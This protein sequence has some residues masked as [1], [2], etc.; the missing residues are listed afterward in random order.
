MVAQTP[1]P[2]AFRAFEHAGW[3]S[4]VTAYRDAWGDL[5]SQAIEPL[6]D[7]VHAGPGVRILDV[8]T[9]PGYVAGAA[10]RRHAEVVGV[11]F[12]APM[13]AEARRREPAVDFREGDAETLPF[14]DA[15]FD[16]VVMSFGLLHLGRPEQALAEAYRVLRPGGRVGFTVWARPEEAVGFE[17]VLGAIHRHGRLDV[18]LPPGP[19]FFRFSDPDECRRVLTGLGFRAPEVVVVPQ[20][21]RH[22]SLD[23]LFDVMRDG[24]V[25]T[26]GLL[27]AQTPA[28]QQAI[29]DEVREAV[30]R[31]Q[32]ADTVELPMPAI[33]AAA[34]KP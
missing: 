17:I 2:A 13:L 4:V 32:R 30:R 10:A 9:G 21:W 1:D 8:A 19:P 16:A 33:L 29:R 12:S 18:P 7:A 28:A 23:G 25:R 14:P 31:Y 6:L 34:A 15:R 26:A 5:T 22:A 11:D 20:V 3:Q 27:R 24:T